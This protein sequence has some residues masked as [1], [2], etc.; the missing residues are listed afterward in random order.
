MCQTG[1]DDKDKILRAEDWR[2]SA[3]DD[4]AIDQVLQSC[5]LDDMDAAMCAPL[6]SLGTSTLPTTS[7]ASGIQ[8]RAEKPAGDRGHP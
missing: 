3:P 1:S 6:L 2:N 7:R 8:P 4:N 5:R